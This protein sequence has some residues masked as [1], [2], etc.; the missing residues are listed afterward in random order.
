ME[1]I[2]G[3]PG[4]LCSNKTLAFLPFYIESIAMEQAKNS[5]VAS[6]L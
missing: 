5:S 6:Y 1:L 2:R 4:A 3:K